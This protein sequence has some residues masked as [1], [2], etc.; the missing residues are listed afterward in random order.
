MR[1]SDFPCYVNVVKGMGKK[2]NNE[3]N[4]EFNNER[5][6]VV[7][8]LVFW[9]IIVLIFILAVDFI[10]ARIKSKP[11]IIIGYDNEKY[12]GIVYDIYVCGDERYLQPKGSKFSC[13]KIDGSIDYEVDGSSSSISVDPASSS[14][15]F[16]SSSNNSNGNLDSSSSKKDEN[17]SS[18]KTDESNSSSKKN[19]IVDSDTSV[20]DKKI[21]I[22]DTS[23]LACADAI[24]YYYEDSN[25]RYYFTCIKSH[26]IKV[27]VNGKE[28]NIKE[29]LVNKIVT[30]DELIKAGFNPLKE[31]K[32][33]VSR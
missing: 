15:G 16:G 26:N 13:P 27:T 30:M 32:N 2:M 7:I 8:R 5:K 6:I 31:S 20:I 29:A 17:N 28:Y 19:E 22:R 24:E 18:N 3:I 4:N 21:T 12:S 14:L 9:V 33:L 23:P 25:Y 10:Y 11:L 1:L